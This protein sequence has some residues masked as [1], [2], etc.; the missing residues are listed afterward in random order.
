MLELTWEA[1]RLQITDKVEE[2]YST[3]RRVFIIMN[4]GKNVHTTL[5]SGSILDS[6][7]PKI[8]QTKTSACSRSSGE[9]IYKNRD[10]LRIIRRGE[11]LREGH[12][13]PVGS[14]YIRVRNSSIWRHRRVAV[15]KLLKFFRR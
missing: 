11:R 2:T 3:S 12:H 1:I 9:Y 6:P 7:L 8:N 15:K 13:A 10:L 5:S 4:S 14:C